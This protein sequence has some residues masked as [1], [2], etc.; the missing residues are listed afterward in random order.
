[1][2][3][4]PEDFP[5]SQGLTPAHASPCACVVGVVSDK[6]FCLSLDNEV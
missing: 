4:P 3:P 5:R 2:S 1:M 6:G